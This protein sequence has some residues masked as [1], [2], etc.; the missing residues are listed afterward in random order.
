MERGRCGGSCLLQLL[1]AGFVCLASAQ[2]V[3]TMAVA[4]L[5]VCG[6][7]GGV[8]KGIVLVGD[9]VGEV[10]GDHLV[11]LLV[12]GVEVAGTLREGVMAVRLDKGLMGV[13]RAYTGALTP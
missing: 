12:C 5:C 2:Q 7:M 9:V 1:H 10:G 6:G 13:G 4:E 8:A 3:G 11:H